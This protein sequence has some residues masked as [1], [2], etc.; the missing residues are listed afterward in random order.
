MHRA[1]WRNTVDLFINAFSLGEMNKEAAL[2]YVT[3]IA[4]ATKYFFHLN[5]D[6]YPRSLPDGQEGAAWI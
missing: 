5:H 1:N 3:F 6:N 4:Q 2:N